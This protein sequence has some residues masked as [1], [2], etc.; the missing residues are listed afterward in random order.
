MVGFQTFPCAVT[1]LISALRAHSPV[2]EC[3]LK[4]SSAVSCQPLG[5]DNDCY[6]GLAACWNICF[7]MK[8]GKWFA[9]HTVEIA[10]RCF[11]KWK[12]KRKNRAKTQRHVCNSTSK[13]LQWVVL[14]RLEAV[15]SIAINK[16]FPQLGNGSVHS[17]SG[18][19]LVDSGNVES[20]TCISFFSVWWLMVLQLKIVSAFHNIGFPFTD[21]GTA[22][23]VAFL[24][25]SSRESWFSRF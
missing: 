16:S 2:K 14:Q 7:R 21:N 5:R 10:Y 9:W 23:R 6:V 24:W 11:L 13:P 12:R 17:K 19:H 18:T 3:D 8:Q 1:S 25:T 15:P 20:F 4:S 22:R